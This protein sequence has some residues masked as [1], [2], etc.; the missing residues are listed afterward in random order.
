MHLNLAAFL[1]FFSLSQKGLTEGL[2][3]GD[4]ETPVPLQS[5]KRGVLLSNQTRIGLTLDKATRPTV[6]CTSLAL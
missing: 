4:P 1:L 2:Q 3:D 6:T 5:H